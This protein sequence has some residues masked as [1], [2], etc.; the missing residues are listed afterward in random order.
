M[1]FFRSLFGLKTTNHAEKEILGVCEM[2]NPDALEFYF[3]DAAFWSCVNLIA[4]AVGKCEVRIFRNN[5]RVKDREWYLWNV[6]PNKNQ[7]ASAFKHKLV[8]KAFK[9]GEALV[10]DEPYGDGIVVADSFDIDD[11][12]PVYSYRNIIIGTRKIERLGERDVLCVRPNWKNMEP[13]ISKMGDSF[14]RMMAA[15]MQQY[16]FNNGQHWKAHV[17]QTAEGA[18]DWAKTFQKI[19]EDQIR[20]FLDS[21]SSILPEMDGYTYTQIS[22]GATPVK[23]DQVR[24][25]QK[26]IWTETGRAFGIPTALTGGDQQDTTVAN[27]QFLEHVIDPFALLLEQEAN[28]KRYTPEEFLAGSRLKVD[29]STIGHFDIFANA[30]NTEKIIG[31]GVFSVNELR[32]RLGED[33]INEEWANKHFMTKNIGGAEAPAEEGGESK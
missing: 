8:S 31:S 32:D 5:Q 18:D 1:G 10:V 21:S 2:I 3:R 9:D 4:N 30:S 23:I 11:S 16:L 22:G 6:Q 29:T 14:L 12:R 27:K 19:L 26:S 20:P 13:L 24:E 25:L 33:P 28:R 17:D 7:N 15:A